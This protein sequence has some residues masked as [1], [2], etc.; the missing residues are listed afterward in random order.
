M[1]SSHAFRSLSLATAVV[2]ASTGAQAALVIPVNFL[3]ADC[4]Q[5]FSTESIDALAVTGVSVTA[6]GTASL[7]ANAEASYALPITTITI[8]SSL[9][10]AKGDA[11]GSALQFTRVYR[12]NTLSLTLANF[13]L[14]TTPKKCW[15]T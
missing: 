13:T 7:V 10:I 14:N 12:G 15:R 9:K 5:A 4:V 11:K 2:A 8:S 1:F 6:L 3:V